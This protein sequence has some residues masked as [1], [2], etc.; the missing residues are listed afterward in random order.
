MKKNTRFLDL[1]EQT[2]RLIEKLHKIDPKTHREEYSE[3][4]GEICQLNMGLVGKQIR[5][6]LSPNLSQDD[7]NDLY[8]SGREG[9]LFAIP[10][11]DPSMGNTFASYASQCVFGYVMKWI[12]WNSSMPLPS[13]IAGAITAARNGKTYLCQDASSPFYHKILFKDRNGVEHEVDPVIIEIAKGSLSLELLAE[14]TEE[15]IFEIGDEEFED[16]VI[17]REAIQKAVA[18]LENRDKKILMMRYDQEWKLKKVAENMKLSIARVQQIEQRAISRFK[19][20][21][22]E[23]GYDV[24]THFK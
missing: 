21:L 7:L 11:F 17:D 12:N 3:I 15:G 2:L 22:E 23:E 13:N 1:K 20:L 9:L 6:F 8:A 5:K 4:V 19:S 10:K 24:A 16:Q 18:Q 14:N